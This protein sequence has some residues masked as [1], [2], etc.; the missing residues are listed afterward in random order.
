MPKVAFFTSLPEDLVRLILAEA[1]P[2]FGS[3]WLPRSASD[4]EKIAEAQDADFLMLYPGIISEDVLRA[5]G[6]LRHIQLLSAGFDSM[7][8][9]LTDSLGIPVSNNGGANSWAVAEATVALIL[10]V[11]RRLVEADAH[12]RAGRWRGDILGYDTYE[13]AGKTVGIV[14]LGNIGKKVAR[15]LCPFETSLLYADDVPD[16]A[17]EQEV[18]IRRLPLDVLL[19][20]SD[21]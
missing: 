2:G 9:A 16:P 6:R 3:V 21:M 1:P 10:A 7:D 14:G 13:L 15:R 5:C 11:L 17:L 12:M 8:L 18:G 4:S 19:Q 20:A